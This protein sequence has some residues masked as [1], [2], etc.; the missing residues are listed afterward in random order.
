MNSFV[1]NVLCCNKR[2]DSSDSGDELYDKDAKDLSY[3]GEAVHKVLGKSYNRLHHSQWNVTSGQIIGAVDDSPRD[4]WESSADPPQ[5]NDDWLPEKMGALISRTQAF[6][7]VMSLGPPDGLFLEAFKESLQLLYDR[8]KTTG[9]EIV[10]RFMFGNIAGVPVNCDR[11]IK[12]LTKDIP[13]DSNLRIWVGAWRRGF[14]WNHAK[15]I[16]VDGVFLHTGGHNLWDRHYLRNNPVHDLSIELRGRVTRDGHRFANEQWSFVQA[17]Q[18]TLIGS[19]VDKIPDGMPLAKRT[20]VT[21]SEWPKGAATFPPQFAKQLIAKS[22]HQSLIVD[23]SKDVKLISIGRQGSM[24][25]VSRP[26]DAAIIAMI[27]SSKTIIRMVLQDIGPVT[28]PGT[29]RALPG[30]TWPTAVLSALGGAIYDRGVDVEIVLSNPGCIPGSLRGTE[31][32]YG[33]GWSC[34]DVASEIVKTIRKN[35]HK[36]NDARLR[37]LVKDNLRICFVRHNKSDSYEDGMSIGLHAKHFIIDDICCYIGSQNLYTCDLAE[38]GLVVDDK[39]TVQNIKKTY[40]DRIW[41]NSYIQLDCDVDAVMDGL[42]VDRNGEFKLFN[43]TNHNDMIHGGGDEFYDIDES[44]VKVLKETYESAMN[45]REVSPEARDD[46]CERKTPSP[47]RVCK[48]TDEIGGEAAASRENEPQDQ[49]E[50]DDDG[51]RNQLSLDCCGLR[52]SLEI[53]SG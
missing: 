24:T 6:C 3:I 40:F 53:A 23:K 25:F 28:I 4:V 43:V 11:V 52:E 42:G 26:S 33:N 18:S 31:A 51:N 12:A 38:W 35:H 13:E 34:V 44:Q 27:E 48:S 14:S 49:D 20:R 22:S 39:E 47:S 32:C 29:K 16:A 30:L 46:E 10:V 50:S 45:S 2:D 15:L 8:S 19:V 5:G 1:E 17:K 7:D 41:K 21:V 36:V 37:A 9:D